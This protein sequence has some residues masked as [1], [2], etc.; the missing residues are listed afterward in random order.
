[1]KTVIE[2]QFQTKMSIFNSTIM[3]KLQSFTSRLDIQGNSLSEFKHV[4]NKAMI[5]QYETLEKRMQSI[6]L[7]QDYIEDL[8]KLKTKEYEE[9]IDR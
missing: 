7:N 3:S 1:M 6:E 4:T 9:L 2:M 5:K 8:F